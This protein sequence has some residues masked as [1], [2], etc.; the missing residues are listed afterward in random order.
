MKYIQDLIEKILSLSVDFIFEPK[1]KPEEGD[2]IL[3]EV[4]VDLRKTYSL[5]RQ[6]AEEHDMLAME[7]NKKTWKDAEEKKK[8]S[9]ELETTL[10]PLKEEAK[11]LKNIFWV[12]LRSEFKYPTG[13]L[14]IR[15]GWKLVA[16]KEE[17]EE[18]A[19]SGIIVVG[20][21]FPF[22]FPFPPR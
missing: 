1:S 15:S 21:S 22:H 18:V 10:S 20:S 13:R 3:G 7:F 16:P 4:S 11:L 12:S 8:N 6:K 17:E 14:A 9:E 2:V 5:Y 19:H